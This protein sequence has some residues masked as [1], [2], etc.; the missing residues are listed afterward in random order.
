MLRIS[1]RGQD[2]LQESRMVFR[3][4]A[5][6]TQ[7]THSQ[8]LPR[9]CS[10]PPTP[11]WGHVRKPV[12]RPWSECKSSRGKPKT[13]CTAG[14][15]CPNPQ[16]DYHGNI[17]PQGACPCPPHSGG[18]P[19]GVGSYHFCRPHLSLRQQLDG[20]QARRGNQM[21]RWHGPRTPATFA[22]HASAG[23]AAGLTDHL[24]SVDELLVFPVVSDL[25]D[26]TAEESRSHPEG[27]AGENAVVKPKSGNTF[28]PS[29][30]TRQRAGL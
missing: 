6:P 7:A 13:F 14:Y 3:A 22:P 8:R 2:V 20:S 9:V 15:A 29:V 21:P 1:P 26:R 19:P 5:A 16:C 25:T 11:L 17:D 23:V 18:G 28:V 12:V 24:W 10:P 30:D 4:N 27:F